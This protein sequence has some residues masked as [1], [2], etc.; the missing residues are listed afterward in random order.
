MISF[1]LLFYSKASYKSPCLGRHQHE[2][3]HP[4]MH[5][6]R[7]N[8]GS[9]RARCSHLSHG[10]CQQATDSWRT[11]TT[12]PNTRRDWRKN[13]LQDKKINWW[14]TP[15]ESPDLNPIE[16][17]WHELK[18]YMRREVMPKTKQELIDGI[19]TFRNTVT[20]SNCREY[21]GHLRK[22]IPN[23]LKVGGAATGY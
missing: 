13:F 10:L 14:G 6:R 4:N 1:S 2:R 19:H 9:T 17:L 22:V 16:N 23:V 15:A 7:D 5:L 18:E 11:R 21:I 8:E 20:V 12:T 3:T